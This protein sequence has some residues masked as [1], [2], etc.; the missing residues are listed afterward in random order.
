MRKKKQIVRQEP[1][2]REHEDSTVTHCIVCGLELA[3]PDGYN[4]TGLCP[5]CATGESSAMEDE[6]P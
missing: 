1:T 5:P 4:Q 3:F 6:Q 2:D